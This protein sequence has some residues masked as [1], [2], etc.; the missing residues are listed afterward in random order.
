MVGGQDRRDWQRALWQDL[1]WQ[2]RPII[3]PCYKC[4]Q[5]NATVLF[6]CREQHQEMSLNRVFEE[7]SSA[8]ESQQKSA[9]WAATNDFCFLVCFLWNHSSDCGLAFACHWLYLL[10]FN[11]HWQ[12]AHFRIRLFLQ[13][14]IFPSQAIWFA[15]FVQSF[16]ETNNRIASR[17][18][19]W[20]ST[21]MLIKTLRTINSFQQQTL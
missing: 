15:I 18:S 3:V 8:F 11:L 2:Q 20:L 14:F 13:N 16:S 7:N 19:F 1:C 4:Q 9:F 17:F 21:V 12:R 5:T 6:Y 10:S